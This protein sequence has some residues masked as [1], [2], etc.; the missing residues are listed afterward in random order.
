MPAPKDQPLESMPNA[1]GQARQ[2]GTE[3]DPNQASWSALSLSLCDQNLGEF[4]S[5]LDSELAD[6][7]TRLD[8]FVTKKS[9]YASC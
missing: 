1:A 2:R 8:H 9:R 6:L 7:E 5:W 4:Q 3:D